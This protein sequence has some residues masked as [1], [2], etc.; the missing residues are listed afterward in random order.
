M[1]DVF[2]LIIF[3]WWSTEI[4]DLHFQGFSMSPSF[5]LILEKCWDL[6]AK[7]TCCE[8]PNHLMRGGDVAIPWQAFEAFPCR[9]SQFC[10]FSKE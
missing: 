5:V 4:V 9:K 1:L 7:I 10:C 3:S 6:K 2:F 8:I